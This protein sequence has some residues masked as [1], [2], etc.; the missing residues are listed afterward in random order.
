MKAAPVLSACAQRGLSQTLVHTGQHYDAR[1][2]QLFFDELG[3]PKPEVHLSVGSGSHAYQTGEIMVRF[4]KVLEEKRPDMVIVYGDVNSAL[5]A[6]VTSAKLSVPVAHVEA[7]LRSFDRNMPEEI[8]RLVTDRLADVLFTPSEDGDRNLLAEG[9][10]RSN[11]FMVGNVMIDTLVRLLPQAGRSALKKEM[12]AGY[13]RYAVV[14]L[15][16]PS[17]VDDLDNLSALMNVLQGISKDIPVLFPVHPRTRARIES[18]GRVGQR[19]SLHLLEPV[20]YLDFLALQKDAAVV[21]TDS[22]GIQ[23]EST[24]LGVPCLTLRDNTER[25]ITVAMG[26]NRLIGRGPA[27]LA[28]EISRVLSGD[29]PAGSIPPLWDGK[30]AERV[31][32]VVC[33]LN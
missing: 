30:A 9:T 27:R 22:G 14:T 3:L 19:G 33:R 11:I 7:G 23:E 21:V 20:G 18:L 10:P 1:M 13:S 28:A 15:H 26:T 31:A 32:E 17:N 24:Y 6:T 2:S 8:N 5:A 12:T 29:A 4:E 25:P 16:R